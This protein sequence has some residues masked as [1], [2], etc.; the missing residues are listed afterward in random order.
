MGKKPKISAGRKNSPSPG[1]SC[2]VLILLL[3]TS[4][5]FS[6]QR[7]SSARLRTLRT[8]SEVFALSKV[9]ASQA[10]P[11]ELDAIVLYSDPEW[12]ALFVQDRTG[13]TFIDT[14]GIGKKYSAGTWV[15]VQAVTGTNEN[16]PTL[17]HPKIT[18]LGRGEVPRPVPTSVAELDGGANESRLGFTEGRLRPCERDYFRVCF[19]LFDGRKAIWLFVPQPESPA[20][21]GLIG[22]VVRARGVISQEPIPPRPT[23]EMVFTKSSIYEASL[24]PGKRVSLTSSNA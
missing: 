9:E 14:H 3:Y 1:N 18:V 17:A 7:D 21:Q 6:Q 8:V 22:A 24:T 12:G 10:Y 4:L 19:R 5:L 16:G 20:S 23:T 15:R 11:V 13:P 2:C